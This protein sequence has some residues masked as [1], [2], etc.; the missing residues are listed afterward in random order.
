MRYI[1]DVD[2]SKPMKEQVTK[3][4]M[5]QCDLRK[6]DIK[7]IKYP[8]TDD[9]AGTGK[10]TRVEFRLKFEDNRLANFSPILNI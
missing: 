1:N 10:N 3:K 9:V 7:K 4:F 6:M 5:V 8:H 2:Q